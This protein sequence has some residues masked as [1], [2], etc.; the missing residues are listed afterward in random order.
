MNKPIAAIFDIDG[1][2]FRDSLLL[3][4][5]EKCV[6]Y[7]VFPNSVNSEIKF[8]KN[9]WENRELDYDDYLYIAA[10]LYT[11]YIADKDILDIDFVA[12]KVIEKES[13]NFIDTLVIESNG[14]RN[15]GTK[16]YLFRGLL[17]S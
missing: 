14:I 11:K 8:H 17:I 7:D 3:K 4:H 5:M 6:S 10:T 16:L 1:T 2:I 13:K 15:R 12:K 9:A